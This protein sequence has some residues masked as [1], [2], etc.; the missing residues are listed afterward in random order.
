MPETTEAMEP[1]AMLSETI[2]T[3]N[4]KRILELAGRAELPCPLCGLPLS[5]DEVAERGI[6]KGVVLVC[7]EGCGFREC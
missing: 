5:G 3:P 6:Y 2:L 4:E 1:D 7:L